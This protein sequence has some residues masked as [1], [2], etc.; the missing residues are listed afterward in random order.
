LWLINKTKLYMYIQLWSL[1]A[2][3]IYIL[4]RVSNETDKKL[5]WK[6]LT[7][8]TLVYEIVKQMRARRQYKNTVIQLAR[9]RS[10]NRLTGS[11]SRRACP[12]GANGEKAVDER[13]RL[14][15]LAPFEN[16]FLFIPTDKTLYIYICRQPEGR[17]Q[18]RRTAR[19]FHY[20]H[21]NRLIRYTIVGVYRSGVCRTK[22]VKKS[23]SR[24]YFTCRKYR[25]IFVCRSFFF[26]LG[27]LNYS[28]VSVCKYHRF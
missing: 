5:T 3:A 28:F 4:C 1:S 6:Y 9:L 2:S 24:F 8:T 22:D 7:I 20:P 27:G 15:A 23:F 19:G 16:P 26:V 25:H 11:R 13:P 14:F 17:A 18:A 21:P 12:I 10:R